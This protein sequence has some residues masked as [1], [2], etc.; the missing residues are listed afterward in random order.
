ME[1]DG[2]AYPPSNNDAAL[3]CALVNAAPALLSVAEAAKTLLEPT[4]WCLPDVCWHCD[5]PLTVC[6]CELAPLRAALADLDKA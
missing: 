6:C 1:T 3:I 4:D 5:E 2:G